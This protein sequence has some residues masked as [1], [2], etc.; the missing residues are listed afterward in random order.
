MESGFDEGFGWLS[1]PLTGE[2]LD[3]AVV[4]LWPAGEGGL[5]LQMLGGILGSDITRKRVE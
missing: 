1:V 2:G 3:P 4:F 5:G